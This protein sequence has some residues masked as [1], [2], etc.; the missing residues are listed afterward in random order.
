LP[1][2]YNV[3]TCTSKPTACVCRVRFGGSEVHSPFP[4][5]SSHQ[6]LA[7]LSVEKQLLL[8][9]TAEN[10]SVKVL[11]IFDDNFFKKESQGIFSDFIVD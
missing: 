7:L 3:E 4:H 1:V 2:S 8:F 9:V 6:P 10:I 5:T 11:I